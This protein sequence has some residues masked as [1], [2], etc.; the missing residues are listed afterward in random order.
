[1]DRG[2]SRNNTDWR[3]LKD[4]AIMDTIR[5]MQ[6]GSAK[7]FNPPQSAIILILEQLKLCLWPACI[8]PLEIAKKPVL[9]GGLQ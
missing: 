4:Y 5:R 8:L 7:S 9:F 2:I 3:R 6:F 1:M